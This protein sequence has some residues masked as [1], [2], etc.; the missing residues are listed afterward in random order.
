MKKVLIVSYYFPPINIVAARRYGIMCKYFKRYG[1]E[2]YIITTN[3]DRNSGWDVCLD[4]E[5]PVER[6]KIIRIGTPKRNYE[7]D[8]PFWNVLMDVMDAG[9]LVSR[10]LTR[11]SIGWY[12]KVKESADLG[13]IRDMDLIIGTYPPMENLYVAYYL[14]RKLKCPYIVDVRDLISD[15]T[16]KTEGNKTCRWLDQ[17]IERFIM[18]NA[19][20]IVTVTPG[21]RDI[22]KMRFPDKAFKVVFNGW[23]EKNS[24][25]TEGEGEY[26]YL[27]YAGSLYLHRLESFELLVNC[28]KKINLGIGNKIQFIVR[29][30]GPKELDAKAKNIVRREEAEDYVKILPSAPEYVVRQEQKRAYINVVLSTVHEDDPALMTTIPGKVYELLNETSAILAVVPKTSDIEKVLRYTQ[31]GIVSVDENEIMDFILK[32][33]QNYRGNEKI[34][35]FTRKRQ[36]QRLCG[37]MDKVLENI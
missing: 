27:Y 7:I 5:L 23:D 19:G 32:N 1:Y 36:A 8:H 10:T 18:N 12:R 14:S 16:D 4:L 3:H 22:L 34:A 29:S 31:K 26:R 24:D 15:Y 35:Y 21:F 6:E 25:E 28:L 13:K 30:I 20:G 2:P 11:N 33:N 37:F 17:R 9:K